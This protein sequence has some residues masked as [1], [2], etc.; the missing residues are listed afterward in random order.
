[1]ADEDK[2]VKAG[3][4]AAL[5]PFADLLDKLAGPAAEEIGLTIKDHVQVF[6]LKR[7]V[8]L[9]GRVREILAESGMEAGRVPFK[10]LFPVVENASIEEDDDLQDRWA[11]MLANAAGTDG[12]SG[13]EPVFPVILKELGI[14][15]VKFL[16]EL[17]E[18]VIRKRIKYRA[19]W[20]EFVN[21]G[22]PQFN[23]YHLKSIYAQAN[24][25]SLSSVKGH[26]NADQERQ[27]RLSLDIIIRNRLLDELY[28]LMDKRDEQRQE[29]G[30]MYRLSE[31]GARFIRACRTP[32]T[33]EPEL[34]GS[35]N[36]VK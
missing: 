27:F 29:V 11:A 21:V 5:K 3:V 18:E 31:L 34:D 22:N 13:V 25:G 16:D 2:L 17:Y 23:I 10:L 26:L 28:D 6:R 20:P 19:E 30:S 9:L 7:R 8:R 1:M 32:K 24:P 35:E 14:Q 15:D 12:R 33:G 36:I 4:E